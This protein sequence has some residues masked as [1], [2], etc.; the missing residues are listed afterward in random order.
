MMF[1]PMLMLI[2]LIFMVAGLV[3]S[4]KLK[5]V[6]STYNSIP[7]DSGLSGKEVAERM[8]RDHDINDVRVTAVEGSLTDHYDPSKKTIN[9]SREIYD[10]RSVASTAVAAHECGHAVQ[11]ATAYAWLQMR[12]KLVPMVNFSSRM[13]NFVFIASLILAFSAQLMNQMLLLIIILQGAITLFSLITLPVEF[14][15]S[16]RALAWIDSR[17]ISSGKQHAMAANALK[18]AASTYVVAA[19]AS[20]ATFFYYLMR[21]LGRRDN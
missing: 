8:L 21:Y 14:D 20:M 17:R 7:I 6:F 18:W 13:M 3:V 4:G 10:G 15:A 1:D 12:S 19:L 16:N 9:L 5:S 11:H 2:T